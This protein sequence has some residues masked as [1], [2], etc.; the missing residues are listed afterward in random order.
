MADARLKDFDEMNDLTDSES[1]K[2][3]SSGDSLSLVMESELEK[4]RK[5]RWYYKRANPFPKIFKNDIRRQFSNMWLNVWNRQNPLDYHDFLYHFF[6]KN[7]VARFEYEPGIAMRMLQQF[8]YATEV[9]STDLS[10]QNFAYI[11]S[12]CEDAVAK[13]HSCQIRRCKNTMSTQLFMKVS[14]SGTLV[15]DL[16]LPKKMLDNGLE[17][18]AAPSM[19]I[20]PKELSRYRTPTARPMFI[21]TLGVLIFDIDEYTHFI[22]QA[23]YR[24]LSFE[25]TP[26]KTFPCC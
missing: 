15:Y 18:P 21:D 13:L 9:S 3:A 24:G 12:I 5:R 11:S 22:T 8:P 19:P 25:A 20:D 17:D 1:S 7:V 6:S 16:H 26:V 23:V 2:D 14:L 4:K 10:V